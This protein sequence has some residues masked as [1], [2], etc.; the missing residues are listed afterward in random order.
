M[1]VSS[2]GRDLFTYSGGWHELGNLSRQVVPAE[3]LSQSAKGRD[4]GLGGLFVVT[5]D[6]CTCGQVASP[7]CA[8]SMQNRTKQNNLPPLLHPP[9]LQR[10]ISWEKT[11]IT[12]VSHSNPASPEIIYSPVSLT[13][14]AISGLQS[15]P[16]SF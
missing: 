13:T 1:S 5:E 11:R 8:K 10:T 4:N 7:L 12:E 6:L 2:P 14:G 16:H 9:T 15:V 3:T